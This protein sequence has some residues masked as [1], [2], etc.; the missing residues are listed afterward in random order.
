LVGEVLALLI[1]WQLK[2]DELLAF[3]GFMFCLNKSGNIVWK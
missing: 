3:L 2:A 1:I